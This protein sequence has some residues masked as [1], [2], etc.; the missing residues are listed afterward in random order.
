MAA[1][2]GVVGLFFLRFWSRTRDSLF[3][4]FAVAFALLAADQALPVLCG[5]PR[6]SLQGVYLLRLAAF[7]LIIVAIVGKNLGRGPR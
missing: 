4:A 1:G 5:L 3:L 2:Y 6:E 7:S